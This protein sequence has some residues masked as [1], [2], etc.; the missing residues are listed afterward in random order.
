[1]VG[2]GANQFADEEGVP[3]ISK[4]KLITEENR[5]KLLEFK[6]SY[7]KAVMNDFSTRYFHS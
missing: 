6:S 1:L 2:Q 3:R 5:N 7:G 4:E